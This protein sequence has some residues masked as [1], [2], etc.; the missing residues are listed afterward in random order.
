MSARLIT[1]PF[2]HYCEKA[3]WAL[4]RAEVP[5]LEEGHLPMFTYRAL[6]RA[7]AART[8]PALVTTTGVALTDSTDI[9]RFAD[10]HGTAPPLAPPDLPD[11]AA[12]EDD[13]DRRL[14]PATR[15]LAYFH[16]LPS[17]RGFRELIAGAEVPA[18]ERRLARLGRPLVT[19]LLARG[20]RID[21]AGAARSRGVVDETFAAVAERL[22][23]GRRYLCGD[24][25]TVADLTF[26]ALAAPV[27]APPAYQRY[28]PSPA[29]QSAGFVALVDELRA[30]PAGQFALR[31]YAEHRAGSP[32]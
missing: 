17:V 26:A 13:F 7:G 30:T 23:D 1:I 4:T 21:A 9:V 20:L 18:W 32:A 2:S 16:L 27:L 22:R 5:F 24:R 31:V 19:R 15:R 28:L 14:G 8:V 12:L 10:A 25:F 29:A 6:R 11:A 3:R